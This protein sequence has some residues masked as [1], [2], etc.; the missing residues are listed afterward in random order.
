MMR[1]KTEDDAGGLKDEAIEWLIRLNESPE[2]P[3]LKTELETWRDQS[4]AHAAAWEKACL[5]WVA[6]G[7]APAFSEPA[8]VEA[9]PA[10]GRAP[11]GR[12]WPVRAFASA[13]AA[14]CLLVM[15]GPAMLLRMEADY[16]TGTAE[17]REVNLPDG[18][19]VTLGPDS[20]IASD[21]AP[22]TRELRLLA[23]EIFLDVAHDGSRPFRVT[24]RDLG[25]QVLGTA[26]NVRVDGDGTEIGLERGSVRASGAV[27]GHAV[28]ETLAPGDLLAVDRQTG[29]TRRQE[30]ALDAIGAWRT[31]RLVVTDATIGSVVEQIGRYHPALIVIADPRF[32][33]LR[34]TGIFNLTDPDKALVALVAPH[35]GKVRQISP[36]AR[37]ITGF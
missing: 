15:L 28:D 33:S 29:E 4:P 7:E 11:S 34:V 20:A 32:A 21:F 18:S 10:A 35:G 12:R 19:R 1:R 6:M 17:I 36:Y 16:R 24:S 37:V 3:A 25:V 8:E 5:L 9:A 26:F 27:A 14:F 2:T 13:A 30:A 22:G 31:K 23:G